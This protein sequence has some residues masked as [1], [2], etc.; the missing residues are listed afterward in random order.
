MTPTPFKRF[1]KDHPHDE[2]WK[3]APYYVQ[4][5][6]S[7]KGYLWCTKTNDKKLAEMRGKAHRDLI[8]AA[9]Y[10]LADGQKQGGGAPLIQGLIDA[11]LD[12]PAPPERTRKANVRALLA[13][14]KVSGLS[15]KD[16]VAR[17]DRSLISNYQS[18]C[19]KARPGDMS[20][21]ITCNSTCRKSRSIFSKRSLNYYHGTP[22]Q[23][24]EEVVKAFFSVPLLKEASG[25]IELPSDEA[26]AKAAAELT[27][28][29][30]RCWI[31][32]RFAG[33]RSGEIREARRSWLDGNILT[34]APNPN[35]YAAKGK[36]SRKI[37]LPQEAVDELLLSDDPVYLVGGPNRY[38]TV[39]R[40]M[41]AMLIKLGFPKRAPLHSLRRLFGSI[42]YTTQGGPAAKDSLGHA[43]LNTT[44]K[45]YSKL[46]AAA[47]PVQ[48]AG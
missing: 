20:A 44:E 17:I 47:A 10:G 31:L 7:G 34:V 25:D 4:F 28:P 35:E 11:Y 24:P 48:W 13:I 5:R 9:A 2:V 22:N 15:G 26:Q 8:V 27:G 30:R 1:P 29:Y 32:A 3:D 36:R 41:P 23:V 18:Y 45:F 42:V 14:L 38:H 43:S 46:M 12:L 16:R 37:A 39:C 40:E 19:M 6:V 21:V 33:L